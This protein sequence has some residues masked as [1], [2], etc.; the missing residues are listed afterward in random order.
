[1]AQKKSQRDYSEATHEKSHKSLINMTSC[2]KTLHM[3]CQESSIHSD[4]TIEQHLA[5]FYEPTRGLDDYKST[6]FERNTPKLSQL[7]NF[8][9]NSQKL[10]KLPILSSNFKRP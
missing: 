9:A 5:K 10:A 7:P 8:W 2:L 6:I 3:T 4:V 1:M